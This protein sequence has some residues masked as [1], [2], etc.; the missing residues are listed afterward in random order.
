MHCYKRSLKKMVTVMN[1]PLFS[2]DELTAMAT[3]AEEAQREFDTWAAQLQTPAEKA[4]AATL[5]QELATAWEAFTQD[6]AA[7]QYGLTPA[8]LAQLQ[9]DGILVKCHTRKRGCNDD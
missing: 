8:E 9:R 5:A 4:E 2:T 6:C 1:D 7:G 3:A